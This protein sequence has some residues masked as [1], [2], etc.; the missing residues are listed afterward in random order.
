MTHDVDWPLKGPGIPHILARRNRFDE[1]VLR[2][3]VTEG[4]NPYFG[5][6]FLMEIEERLGIRSTFF[7]RPKYDDGSGVD[8]YG[9]VVKALLEGGW[10][11]GLH[12]NDATTFESVASEKEKLEKVTGGP[13]YGSRVHYLRV[14]ETTFH[15]L[16]KAHIKYD[17]S[18]MYRKAEVDV[19]NSGFLRKNGLIVFP[20]TFMDTYLFTYMSLTEATVAKFVLKSAEKLFAAGAKILTLLWHDNSILM[21]GGRAY[22]DVI[23]AL[24][25]ISN[26]TFLKG[27]EAFE[28][29][30]KAGINEWKKAA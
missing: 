27:V 17:S 9:D 11:I 26:I 7:F 6:P 24:S 2:K 3:V 16:A 21:R 28:M 14:T 15:N 1:E 29:V 19:N 12:V 25:S 4:F 30:R 13:I 5:I 10:E 18:L 8:Q 22:P 23:K 20:V